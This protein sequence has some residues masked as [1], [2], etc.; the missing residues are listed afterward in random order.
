MKPEHWKRLLQF[1]PDALELPAHERAALLELKCRDADGNPDAALY[2]AALEMIASHDAAESSNAFD[3]PFE[4]IAAD[5]AMVDHQHSEEQLPNAIGVWQPLRI[6]GRGGMG[7]VYLARRTDG[8]ID[9]NVALKILQGGRYAGDAA[10]RFSGEQRILSRLEHDNIA[11]LYDGGIADDGTPFLVMEYV[12]GVPITTYCQNANLGVHKK[13]EL[14]KLVCDAVQFAHLNLIVHRDIKPSN[15]FVTNNGSVKLLDFGIAKLLDDDADAAFPLTRTGQTLMTPE[16]AAPEQVLGQSVTTATDVYSLGIVLYELLVGE[17]PYAFDSRTPSAIERVIC[18]STPTRPSTAVRMQSE[19]RGG[20]S[21]R[22]TLPNSSA[23]LLRGDLDTIVLKALSKDPA[24]RYP[25]AA[26]LASDLNNFLAGLPVTARPDTPGYRIRKFVG[27]H[28]IGVVSAAAILVALVVGLIGTIWQASIAKDEAAKADATRNFIQEMFASADPYEGNTQDITVV[29]V[30]DSASARISRD[31]STAPAVEAAVRMTIGNT[32]LGLGK[33]QQAESQ[34]TIAIDQLEALYGRGSVETAEAL[35]NLADLYIQI[36]RFSKSDSLF[37]LA[38]AIHEKRPGPGRRD[39]AQTA[40]GYG[41]VLLQTGHYDEA[42]VS[43]ERALGIMQ[44]LPTPL[45][46]REANSQNNYRYMLGILHHDIGEF[47]V[48]DSLLS[49][50]IDDIKSQP[51]PWSPFLGGALQIHAWTKDYLGQSELVAPMLNEA[52]AFRTERFGPNHIEVG[53]TLNDLAYLYQYSGDSEKADSMY[54]RALNLFRSVVG[55]EERM[56]A[57]LLNNRAALYRSTGRVREAIPM[58]EEAVELQ[59]RLLGPEHVDV[60]YPVNGLGHCYV[61]LKDYE[62]AEVY[63]QKALSIREKA[64]PAGHTDIASVKISLAEVLIA[65]NRFAEAAP[66]VEDAVQA[67]IAALGPEHRDTAEAEI[68]LA[69]LR[70]AQG[71]N[72][73]AKVVLT[74]IQPIIAGT[75]GVDHVLA[76]EIESMLTSVQ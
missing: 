44:D 6:L 61:T 5:V 56:V 67:Q 41:A 26:H 74:R 59:T 58:L 4:G 22:R 23:K 17:R 69:R 50:A 14:F 10:T 54:V 42:R 1:V 51:K 60:S 38:L 63:Y 76:K 16:Y 27:R 75:Y 57:T 52:L 9:R 36:S 68:S 34:L 46:K 43:L 71:R 13:V 47:G 8:K 73:D 28:R 25:S 62:T 12:D 49:I 3:S 31:L 48:A 39:L 64:L 55:N 18:E 19:S 35:R 2:A 7:V 45:S 37:K 20:V 72:A 30:L 66:L 15:I 33:Y 21:T 29:Q 24:R 53:Y 65:R 70:I 11:R 40:G 32:Y